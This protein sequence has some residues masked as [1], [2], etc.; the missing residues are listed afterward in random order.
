MVPDGQAARTNLRIGDRILSVN[1]VDITRATHQEAVMALIAPENEMVLEVQHDPPPIGL[2][3]IH[4]QK[5]SPA[6]KI[7]ISIKGG[8]GEKSANPLDPTDE[9]VFITKVRCALH[10]HTQMIHARFCLFCLLVLG[11][12]IENPLASLFADP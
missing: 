5:I 8:A 7:G 3:E 9:G 11:A 1:G 12:A 6:E 4:I 10:C 2:A